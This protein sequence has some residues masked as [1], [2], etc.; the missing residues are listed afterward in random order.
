L[1][2]IAPDSSKKVAIIGG[3]P[4]GLTAAFFLRKQGHAVDVLDKMPEMGGMLRYGIPEYRLPKK[5]LAEEVGLMTEMGIRMKN[6]I[7]LGKDVTLPKLITDYDA[8]VIA[9]GAW[10]STSVRIPGENMNGVVG[11]I[12]FLRSVHFEKVDLTGKKVAILGGGNTAM[13]A[14]RTA[15]RLNAASVCNLYRRTKAEMPAEEIEIEEAAE[16]GVVFKYLVAP[17]EIIGE[18]DVVKRIKLQKMRLGDPDASGR[19]S[20]IPIDGETETVDVDLV[21]V[22]IGQQN[23]NTG[24]DGL[25]LTKRGTIAADETTFRTNL[26][27]VFAIGDATN[28]GAGIA[29]SAIGE[30][31]KA[32]E[33]IGAFLDGVEAPYREPVLVKRD[34]LTAT[35]FADRKK[36]ARAKMR[37]RPVKE[38][39]GSMSVEVNYGYSAEEAKKEASRCLE[40]GCLDYYECRLV[41]YVNRYEVE[42]VYSGAARKYD[43]AD[44]HPYIMR[45]MEKCVLCGL[46]VRICEEVVGAAALGLVNRGFTTFVAPELRRPLKDTSCNSCGMCVALCPTGALMEKSPQ[47]PVPAKETFTET[48]CDLCEARCG[49]IVATSGKSHV[50]NLPTEGG[51]LCEKGRFGFLSGKKVSK[52]D[53]PPEWIVEA[54]KKKTSSEK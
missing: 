41:D 30:G 17:L 24:L 36:Q 1:P 38:R 29:I 51:L 49:M 52:L 12:D 48:V 33:I 13:D 53:A 14:C 9:T 42:P 7:L 46:C 47:K 3:G 22:A 20:P 11:G 16:E 2:E 28:Q 27:K 25:A 39:K 32:A 15:V 45:N 23:D 50:R 26:E 21:I 10:Q 31:R 54:N 44:E 5:V 37:H 43:I 35:D 18:N 4:G 34:D 6:N 8:V 19:R 40:C